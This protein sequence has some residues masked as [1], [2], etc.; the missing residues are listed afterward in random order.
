[1]EH[2][3]A[4]WF[5]RRLRA[6]QVIDTEYEEVYIYG[7]EII[8]SCLISTSI[9]LAIGVFTRQIL[10]TLVFLVVF[11][12][13]RQYTGGYH[14]NSYLMCKLCTVMSF[15]ISVLL[16]N[17]FP[18]SRLIFLVLAVIG[19][20]I[21]WLFGPI[22][23]VHKP[24]TDQEK[25]KHKITGLSLFVIWSVIGFVFSFIIPLICNTIFYT[26]CAII[27]LMII[28][29]LERRICHEKAH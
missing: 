20:L 4:T 17:T 25:K 22:E 7:L 27:F 26:L 19:C 10:P 3:I 21:I 18:I 6:K 5:C 29:L 1:M 9:I 11:V 2:K 24:L 16:A 13:I 28:P 12:L 8:L 23:N 15:G 14:A